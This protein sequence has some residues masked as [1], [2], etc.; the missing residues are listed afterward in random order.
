MERSQLNFLEL[1]YPP[2][3]NQEAEWIKDDVD[4]QN[5]LSQSN[6]YMIGQRQEIYFKYK[7]VSECG[8][9]FTF[10]VEMGG[11]SS[12]VSLD[13]EA[14]RKKHDAFPPFDIEIEFGEKIVRIWKVGPGADKTKKLIEWF[15][16]EKLLYDKWRGYNHIIGLD[17]VRLFTKYKLHYVGISKKED[18][19]KRLVV[20]PHDKRL[21]VLSN[22]TSVNE[23]SRLTDE[24]VL[25]FFKID[26]LHIKMLGC[27]NELDSYLDEIIYSKVPEYLKVVADAEKAFVKVLQSEYNSQRFNSYP[28]GTDGLYD[29][30]MIRYGYVINE[31]IEFTTDDDTMRGR[32]FMDNLMLMNDADLIFI[33]GDHVELVKWN[34]KQ[35]DNMPG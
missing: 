26:P 5:V 12:Q 1:V 8:C 13:I 4:V 7:C 28:K 18:S 33:I 14:V 11:H 22:E 35:A 10:D 29:A 3:S 19:L 24:I 9:Y 23:S 34:N 25:F 32:Y 20:R 17:D 27:E 31:D 21:R 15:T 16:T 2:V 30:G 6:L